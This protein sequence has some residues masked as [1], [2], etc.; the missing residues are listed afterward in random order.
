MYAPNTSGGVGPC[1][2]LFAGGKGGDD[3]DIDM[4]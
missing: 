4:D 3:I 1:T 2:G